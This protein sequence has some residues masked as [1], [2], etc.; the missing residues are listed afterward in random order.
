VPKKEIITKSLEDTIE[1]TI[2]AVIIDDLT[3][4]HSININLLNP[5]ILKLL[6]KKFCSKKT[7]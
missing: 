1:V 4:G 7:L 5:L 6:I 2:K 3:A